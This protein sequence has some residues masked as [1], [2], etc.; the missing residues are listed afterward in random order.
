MQAYEERE[1]ARISRIK[2]ASE[3]KAHPLFQVHKDSI[4]KEAYQIAIGMPIEPKAK[5]AGIVE[6]PRTPEAPFSPLRIVTFKVHY[7]T[8][9][10][11]RFEPFSSVRRSTSS[12]QHQA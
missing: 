9:V 6:G 7:T 4:F 2:K 3:L 5:A 12:V 10:S 8:N 1:L 11:E